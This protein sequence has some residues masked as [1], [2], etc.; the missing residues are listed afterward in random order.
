[1]SDLTT[2]Q[3]NE[4]IAQALDQLGFEDVMGMYVKDDDNDLRNTNNPRS[5]RK[6]VVDRSAGTS[7]FFQKGT[8]RNDTDDEAGTLAS[9]RQVI[10][11]ARDGKTPTQSEADMQY[12][13]DAPPEAKEEAPGPEDQP[14]QPEEPKNE[15]TDVPVSNT[16][17]SLLELIDQYVGND[18]LQVFGDTGAGKSK[19]CMEAAQQAIAAGKTVYYLDTER[20][21]TKADIDSLKGCQYR[22]TPV[23]N[24]IDDIVQHLPAVDMV[25]LDSI[26]FPVLTTYARLSLKQK[27]DALLK[28]I[29][30]FGDLK[31]W[32][33]K[34][35]GVAIVTNQPESEFNKEKGHIFRPFGD[36]SQ[37]AAKEIWK[38][39]IEVRGA[40][41]T[42]I[43][44]SAFRSRSV[45]YGS[46]IAFMKIT[47]DGV[48]VI[49]S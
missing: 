1:M 10:E 33:Y 13:P 41:E 24:E 44:I 25:I 47:G 20:N 19:F 39:K 18:V 3:Q 8:D 35:N 6:V 14:K 4:Y 23:L 28:L 5:G 36:K 30:I 42:K 12:R 26:G 22:Y 16:N 48:E 15:N 27:G 34:N 38:T 49:Q 7:V 9:I 21:L 40:N 43:S 2:E 31:T 11:D 29:A 45:G 32:A 37:F 46:K 17:S